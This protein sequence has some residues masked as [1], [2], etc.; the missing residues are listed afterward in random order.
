MKDNGSRVSSCEISSFSF[1][2]ET[3]RRA[4]FVVDRFIE[5][6]SRQFIS[7]MNRYADVLFHGMLWFI[8]V[9]FHRVYSTVIFFKYIC[10]S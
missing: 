8:D 5:F 4:Y 1:H 7:S 2:D 9:S 6:I 10:M 3:F